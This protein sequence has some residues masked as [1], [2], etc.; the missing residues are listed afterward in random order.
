MT[1]VNVVKSIQNWEVVPWWRTAVWKYAGQ[2]VGKTWHQDLAPS[3]QNREAGCGSRWEIWWAMP[4]WPHW[5][6]MNL[7]SLLQANIMPCL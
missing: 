7:T 3:W 1:K 5:A 2:A 4:S 6:E